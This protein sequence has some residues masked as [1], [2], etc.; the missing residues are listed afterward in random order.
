[1]VDLAEW[2]RAFRLLHERA[3]SGKLSSADRAD[4]QA[5]RDE[6]ARALIDAQRLAVDPTEPP[7]NA[8]RVARALQVDLEAPASRERAVTA[9]VSAGGFSVLLAKAPPPHKEMKCSIRIPGGE[10]IV[11]TVVPAGAKP[12]LASTQVS[13]VFKNLGDADRER[14]EF[15]IFD[16]ALS[17][18]SK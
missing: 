14:L 15:L 8:L 18:L 5:A 7:R 6:L 9:T 2:L 13:F 10:P 3:R 4:Y 16:T 17:Q 12:Q 11:A 1:M